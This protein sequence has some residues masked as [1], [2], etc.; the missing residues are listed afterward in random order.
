MKERCMKIEWKT[1]IN[2]PGLFFI[3]QPYSQSPGHIRQNLKA[4][5]RNVAIFCYFL[6]SAAPDETH[7]LRARG[8]RA[9]P[10][11]ILAFHPKTITR[12]QED[13]THGSKQNTEHPWNQKLT[14]SQQAGV[15]QGSETWYL[16]GLQFARANLRLGQFQ[17]WWLEIQSKSPLYFRYIQMKLN[18]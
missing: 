12:E 18:R 14:Q 15:L 3:D 10:L 4:T 9:S 16:V 11:S 5:K 1:L 7:L 2:G 17:V 6:A 13:E 8:S